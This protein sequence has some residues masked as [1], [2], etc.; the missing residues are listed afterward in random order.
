MV[1]DGPNE[2]IV[3]Y[4]CRGNGYGR[5]R[6]RRETTA[7]VQVES[8]GVAGGMP[9]NVIGEARKVGACR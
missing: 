8:Q 3:Q 5:T 9:F 4:T 1:D 6:I 2:V 7:L